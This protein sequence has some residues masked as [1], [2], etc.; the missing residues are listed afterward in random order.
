MGGGGRE[1]TQ[2]KVEKKRNVSI[3]DHMLSR[4]KTGLRQNDFPNFDF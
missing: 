1:G 2:I 4:L 3:V